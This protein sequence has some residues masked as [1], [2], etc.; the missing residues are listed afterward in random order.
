MASLALTDG[1]DR[2]PVGHQEPAL[3]LEEARGEAHDLFEDDLD[4][5]TQAALGQHHLPVGVGLPKRVH[6]HQVSS[7]GFSTGDTG[8]E[9]TSHNS[10]TTLTFFTERNSFSGICDSPVLKCQLDKALPVLHDYSVDSWGGEEGLF[11]TTGDDDHRIPY[12]TPGQQVLNTP[13]TYWIKACNSSNTS[14]C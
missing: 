11:C 5:A 1:G 13:L 9:T 7:E 3:P 14:D 8:H 2:T 10:G 12:P 6:W 4:L